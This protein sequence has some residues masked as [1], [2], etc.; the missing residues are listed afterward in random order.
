MAKKAKTSPALILPF[1]QYLWQ[2]YDT[3]RK[4][5]RRAYKPLT[6]KFLDFNDPSNAKAF[7]R[8]PQ[9]E[10]LEIYVFL[11]ESLGNRHLADVFDDWSHDKGG[12]RMEDTKYAPGDELFKN[13]DKDAMKATFQ[14][15][16][17]ARQPYSNYIFALTMGVGKTV[18]MATCIFYEFLLAN[19]FPKDPLY[20]HNALVFAPDTTVLQSLKEIMTFP[21]DRVV[22][23]EYVGWLDANITFHFLDD[24]GVTLNTLDRSEFNLI[25]SNTQKIILKKTAA[26]K[27][28]AMQLFSQ[29]VVDA[30][31]NADPEYADLYAIDDE[32]SLSTNQRFKKI[33]RLSQLGLYVDE[34]HH[35]FGKQLARD[36]NDRESKTSLRLTIDILAKELER[37]GTH[38]VS[39]FN[40]TGTPY[41]D[42][43]LLSE[44]VYEYSLKRAINAS[45]L[46]Q[47]TVTG[48][49]NARTKAFIR[50]AIGS[51]WE[52]HKGK[53][54]EKMLPKMAIFASKVE[55]LDKELRPAVEAVLEDLG[56]STDSI[57]VNVG[58]PKYT[59]NDD[60]REFNSLDTPESRKQFILLVGKGK[61]GW[62]CRS[63]FS[64]ALFREPK[65]KIFVL[66]ATMR[67]LRSITTVQR[68]GAVYLSSEN[69]EILEK[70]LQENFRMTVEDL[71]AAGDKNK[72]AVEVR[73]TKPIVTIPIRIQR[74][75]Y[76]LKRKT[77]TG[78]VDLETG[79]IDW[80][81]YRI[82]ATEKSITDLKGKARAEKDIT[83]LREEKV[84]S[85]MSLVA[86]TARYLNMGPLE[87]KDLLDK[88]T[89]GPERLLE[90]VNR[91]NDVLYDWIIPRLFH[92]LYD[93]EEFEN[94][95]KI[96]V[97]LVKEP[98]DGYY[99]VHV[100]PE[101]LAERKAAAYSANA[102]KSFH[103]D[104][105]CF[106]SH[107][108]MQFF[109]ENLPNPGVS[110][111]WFTGMLTH[112]QT[113]FVVSYIDPDS[114]ALRT[115]YPD[116][117][118]QLKDGSY[119][120]VEIKGDNK[121]DDPVV[122]AKSDYASKMAAASGIR[123][124]I[125]KGSEARRKVGDLLM[126]EARLQGM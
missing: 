78:K 24:T 16:K 64:V 35:A 29:A 83:A 77:E 126:A 87:V 98:P 53:R 34:A 15:L 31:V 93:L 110:K 123:Y 3:H 2:F 88:T 58:D 73:T 49:K 112:G 55:E 122:H 119:V 11:K 115:Y 51:F 121:I 99:T 30:A 80:E 86:E 63:L 46:K 92:S 57:L 102:D 50:H 59:S 118:L 69:V 82:T 94:T 108:E 56:I 120:I 79:K 72:K 117:L 6:R 81:K 1:Y 125:V 22:P 100:L 74:K 113:D 105:Y 44:V 47:V 85:G 43:R 14:E 33:T 104:K 18:L 8:K 39:C 67:C 114:H 25:I 75:M 7:L 95:E 96:E 23:P 107:P 60:I 116:F 26:E 106:D 109:Q 62:N 91:A 65:S 4:E 10:A 101:L 97:Q 32:T 54:Y 90:L 70:E 42:N 36:M 124:L 71:N 27:S 68:H 38:V 48:V 21:K 12:F 111:I 37:S 40:Y 89:E 52:E 103:L 9:F 41:A 19:K 61:E 66:Q 17:D 13:I 76:R 5:I 20:C 45:Y 84:F 28:P